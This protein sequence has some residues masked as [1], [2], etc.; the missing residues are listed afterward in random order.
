MGCRCN[1]VGIGVR[2]TPHSRRLVATSKS[3]ESGHK[4]TMR[5]VTRSVFSGLPLPF[6]GCPP[7]G[8]VA[9]YT[10]L[11]PAAALVLGGVEEQPATF[12]ACT[13]LGAQQV[14]LHQQR[15]G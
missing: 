10:H 14:L 6:P 5:L 8:A 1:Y 4:Q 13:P 7:F 11:A 12:L 15:Q 2:N 9:A 3:A